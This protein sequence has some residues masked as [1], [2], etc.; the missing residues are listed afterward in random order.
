VPVEVLKWVSE[1]H[2]AAERRPL[3]RARIWSCCKSVVQCGG[4]VFHSHRSC[5]RY[6]CASPQLRPGMNQCKKYL[7]EGGN[8]LFTYK[9]YIGLCRLL[10]P[11]MRF[12]LESECEQP[13]KEQPSYTGDPLVCQMACKCWRTRFDDF[14]R[15]RRMG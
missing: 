14:C 15:V 11:R 4:L 10:E 6:D 7:E 13:C 5:A 3:H 12:E 8:T 1:L 2:W 9:Y